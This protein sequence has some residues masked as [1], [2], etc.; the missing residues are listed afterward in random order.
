MKYIFVEQLF[1]L[2]NPVWD[3]AHVHTMTD[4]GQ[5]HYLK[6]S[7]NKNIYTHANLTVSSI[8]MSG[9]VGASK[10]NL[11]SVILQSTKKIKKF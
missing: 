9:W 10:N 3:S 4:F 2:I 11:A 8:I 1:V 6:F 7:L 5:I